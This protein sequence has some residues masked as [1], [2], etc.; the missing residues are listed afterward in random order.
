MESQGGGNPDVVI[1]KLTEGYVVYGNGASVACSRVEECTDTVGRMLTAQRPD[2][3]PEMGGVC[4]HPSD[5]VQT[6]YVT[7]NVT[8][9]NV[10]RMFCTQCG[11]RWALDLG[12]PAQPQCQHPQELWRSNP[13][14]QHIVCTGCGTEIGKIPPTVNE[15]PAGDSLLEQVAVDQRREDS[16]HWAPDDPRWQSTAPKAQAPG[17]KMPRGLEAEYYNLERLAMG[18]ASGAINSDQMWTYAR[19]VCPHVPNVD[20]NEALNRAEVEF[21]ETRGP[22]PGRL[23]DGETGEYDPRMGPIRVKGDF[24]PEDP[25]LFGKEP[26]RWSGRTAPNGMASIEEGAMQCGC[27]GC[28][29]EAG[30]GNVCVACHNGK[31][32]HRMVDGR[33]YSTPTGESFVFRRPPDG[34]DS[35]ETRARQP[36]RKNPVPDDVPPRV[37]GTVGNP[38]KGRSTGGRK[39]RA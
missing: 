21:Y 38:G 27:P 19:Q 39:R 23:A 30:A 15:W 37:N 33:E 31:H 36:R 25:S 17:G 3:A 14:L 24:G 26:Q 22:Q 7:D 16:R 1:Y 4:E 6:A 18:I 35:G 13:A 28:A 9:G 5:K 2:R 34:G 10:A 20:I 29:F 11:Y 12:V 8:G 32:L